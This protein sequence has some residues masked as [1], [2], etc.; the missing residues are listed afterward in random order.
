MQELKHN[1][2]QNGAAK[3]TSK[4]NV[5][6]NNAGLSNGQPCH[7]VQDHLVAMS[8]GGKIDRCLVADHV[9]DVFPSC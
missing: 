9:D 2:K 8:F 7:G 3:Q 6:R 1:G 4:Q 5:K